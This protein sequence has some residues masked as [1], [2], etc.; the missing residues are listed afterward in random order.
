MTEGAIPKAGSA[1]EASGEQT[2][3]V[4]STVVDGVARVSLNR[5][6]SL[7]ALNK[8]LAQS[9]MDTFHEL[10]G[11]KRVRAVLLNGAGASFCV[12]GD[13]AAFNDEGERA[14]RYIKQVVVFFH[15][16]I[17]TISRMK[18][19]VVAAVRGSAAGGGMALAC[20]CDI[21]IAA[22]TARFVM[23]YTK[24]GLT[25][26]GS[27]TWFLPRL[28]GLH[29]SLELALL[30]RELSA[31]TA[32][33]WG[34]INDVVADEDL[35]M[36]AFDIAARMAHG[37]TEALGTAKKLIRESLETSLETQMMKEAVAVSRAMASREAREGID[38]FF[39]KRQPNFE[40]T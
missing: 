20:A 5:P 26:D 27:S 3:L 8:P 17:S 1:L 11:D 10:E 25:P 6:Q 16:V 12:G 38:A 7:N 15:E 35:D 33:N 13:L 39:A 9:L 34:I 18:A 4:L 22:E 24:V 32:L 37:A 2:K 36:K 29:R 19:P 28:V 30:N 14:P 40:E 21:V 31:H 23:A